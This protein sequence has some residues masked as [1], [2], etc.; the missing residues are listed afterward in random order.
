M[1]SI[2]YIQ[3]TIRSVPG[4]L[5]KALR[6]KAKKSGKSLNRLILE[7]LAKGAGLQQELHNDLDHFFGS[8]VEDPRVDQ[9]LKAQRKIDSK[10]WK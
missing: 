8:W 7:S 3:Y 1:E 4:D 2:H 5:D 9:A 10:L 6:I